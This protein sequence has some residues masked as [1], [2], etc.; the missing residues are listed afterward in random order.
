[1][2]RR[3]VFLAIALAIPFGLL[4]AD[5]QGPVEKTV[6]TVKNVATKTGQTVS[7]GAKATGSALSNGAEAT[8]RTVW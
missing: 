1:M 7:H 2:R 5:D 8:E 3:F 4:K 6:N